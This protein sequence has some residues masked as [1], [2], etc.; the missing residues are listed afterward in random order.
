MVVH[1]GV[2]QEAGGGKLKDDAIWS[3][4]SKLGSKPYAIDG[5][6]SSVSNWG[7]KMAAYDYTI[8]P[9]D[10]AVGVFAHEY[11]HDLGLPD[12]YDTKY[13]GQ[14]EPVES[15]SMS[16]GSWAGKIAGTE[17]T[18]FSPQ[19]KEFFQKNMKGN[20]ANILEVDYDKLSK[21]I[22][23]ATYRSKYYKI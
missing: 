3:H 5:T 13:S 4:R 11:G 16:G 22:G 23:V 6:K 10:G 8:E 19:N 21:G 14:G 17:P 20:W 18:S 15:W 12:E 7:G 1:A 9:E 2:G